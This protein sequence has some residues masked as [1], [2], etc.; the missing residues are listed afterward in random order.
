M[1][2]TCKCE[3]TVRQAVQHMIIEWER[4]T[5]AMS[6]SGPASE[7]RPAAEWPPLPE[8]PA[9]CHPRCAS[10]EKFVANLAMGIVV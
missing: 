7:F 5:A 6:E 10:A 8:F 2:E 9:D 1:S 3:A 4:E